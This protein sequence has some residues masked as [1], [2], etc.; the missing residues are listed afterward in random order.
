MT[1]SA[2]TRHNG[3]SLNFQYRLLIAMRK[4]FAFKCFVLCEERVRNLCYVAVV[5]NK[6][7]HVSYI[8]IICAILL[9]AQISML[10]YTFRDLLAIARTTVCTLPISMLMCLD[11][12]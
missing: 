5:V 7:L 10:S 1:G 11:L 9:V 6:V 12:V 8:Y 3:A 2:K 4:I